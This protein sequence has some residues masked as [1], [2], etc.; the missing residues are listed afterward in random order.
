M[1][2]T[3]KIIALLLIASA[4]QG[5][6]ALLV[7]AKRRTTDKEWKPYETT[8]LAQLKNFQPGPPLALNQYGGRTDRPHRSTGF[9]QAVRSGG[10]WIMIDPEGGE[11]YQVACNSVAVNSTT[12]GQAALA[13]MH[14]SKEQWARAT[15]RQLREH[16][17]NMLGCWSDWQSFREHAPLPYTTQSNFMSTFGRKLHVVH[18]ASGHSGYTGDVIPVFHPDFPAFC[19]EHAQKMLA[20]TRADPWLVGHFSDNEMPLKA[21]QLKKCL[22]LPA[23]NPNHQAALKWLAEKKISPDSEKFSDEI[24]QEFL[25]FTAETYFSNVSQAI[26]ESDPNHLYLGA[27]FHGGDGSRQVLWE[28]AGRYVDVIAMNWYGQWT[29]DRK[30]MDL[31]SRWSQRPFI[32]TEWYAKGMDS[33]MGNISGAGWTV[34]TQAD[35]GRFYQNFTIALAG[36]PAC[37]GWHWFKYM[38]N[39]PTN[40]KTDPSNRDSN[41]GFVNYLYQPY[42]D[43]LHYMK[44]LNTGIYPLLDFLH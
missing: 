10:R 23:D 41:K 29:P 20:A 13:E 36:H 5:N 37:V 43:L 33:G 3:A 34:K 32:I 17:F 2:L 1:R 6:N 14:G 25:R 38:D 26:R 35:R 40:T 8:T 7:E 39:D 19:R 24:L 42:P 31:W 22:A 9:F 27:R 4:V 18:Q 28:V 30:Q 44:E 16:G 12:Q 21:D 11:W 15:A